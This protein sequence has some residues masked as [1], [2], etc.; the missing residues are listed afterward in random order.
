M[1]TILFSLL[2]LILIS[3]TSA[4]E[5]KGQLRHLVMFKFKDDAKAEQITSIEKHFASLPKKINTIIDFEWGTN[6]S[7]EKKN[8]GLT[9]C[10]F[11]SFKDQAGLDV[12][13]PHPAHQAF[14]KELLP[15]LDKVVVIDYI[16]Q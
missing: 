9:H 10:F 15:I 12:Y 14:V 6:V 5:E 3:F 7:N 4:A 8:D 13:S 2:S 16:A 11:V 1:K